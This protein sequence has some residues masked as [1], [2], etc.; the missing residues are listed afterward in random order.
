M[1]FSDLIVLNDKFLAVNN[2]DTISPCIRY[3]IFI[4]EIIDI[5]RSLEH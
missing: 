4:N 5:F 3:C 1:I 2:E